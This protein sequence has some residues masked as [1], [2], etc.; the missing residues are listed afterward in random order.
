M[1]LET[2]KPIPDFSLD[3]PQGK[4]SPSDVKGKWLVLYFYPK[5]NTPGCTIEAIDFSKEKQ[6]FE[7]L[8]AVIVG[9]SPD[10]V[11]SHEGFTSKQ[12]LSIT[13]A[14]D[15]D[16]E[17]CKKLGVWQMKKNY[18][19]EYEGVV[20]T[21]YLIDPEGKV[22]FVWSPVKVKGHVDEVLV[23]LNDLQS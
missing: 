11:K 17:V 21:T 14:S 19:K 15:P 1:L 4:F 18:G 23:K 3:T 16:K 8:G 9:V 6:N 20:R 10:S 2:G 13:L 22:A 7:E 12:D 5:D